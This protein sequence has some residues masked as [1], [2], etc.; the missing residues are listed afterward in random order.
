MI[1]SFKWKFD[2]Y[3]YNWFLFVDEYFAFPFQNTGSYSLIFVTM[4]LKPSLIFE[5]LW[6]PGLG[7][8]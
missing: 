6:I 5:G 3:P 8:E 7:L 4:D 1:L 2:G